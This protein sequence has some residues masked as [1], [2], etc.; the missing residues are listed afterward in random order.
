[1]IPRPCRKEPIQAVVEDA[2][3]PPSTSQ[4]HTDPVPKTVSIAPAPDSASA[5]VVVPAAIKKSEPVISTDQ[6]ND[7]V[8]PTDME[9]ADDFG[10]STKCIVRPLPNVFSPN[11]DGY[12]DS[13][14]PKF[15]DPQ[16]IHLRIVS[17]SSGEVVFEA[18]KVQEWTGRDQNG[19]VLPAGAYLYIV[20]M[21]DKHGVTDQATQLVRLF[22]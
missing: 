2:P 1:M 4:A 5:P 18:N 12:N 13:Y 15:L 19:Q 21:V 8:I 11:G 3:N 9:P 6:N 10:E 17:M 22:R 16:T 20:E 14:L 7:P